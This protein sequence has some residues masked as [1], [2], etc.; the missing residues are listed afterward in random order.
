MSERRL[1]AR[2]Y[3]CG[4]PGSVEEVLNEEVAYGLCVDCRAALHEWMEVPPPQV[5]SEEVP[6]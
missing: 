1:L 6:K 4:R 5:V 3:R 2:C